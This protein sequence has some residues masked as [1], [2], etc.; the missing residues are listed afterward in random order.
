M[1]GG[2]E[3]EEV[4]CNLCGEENCPEWRVVRGLRLVRSRCGLVFVSPR[5]T[6]AAARQLYGDSYFHAREE[7]EVREARFAMYRLEAREVKRRVGCGRILDV[8]CGRGYFLNELGPEFEKVGVDVSESALEYARKQLGITVILGSLESLAADA[9]PELAPNSYD[10]VYFRGVLQH[11]HDPLENLARAHRLLKPGGLL[12][13]TVVPNI[14]SPAA[15]LFGDEFRLMLPE[16]MIYY[17]MPRTLRAALAKAGFGEVE[18]NFPYFETPYFGWM[19]AP[20]AVAGLA[21]RWW[22][23]VRGRD[24]SR[25]LSPPFYGSV[26]D[27]YARAR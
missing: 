16:V 12:V 8:G 15:R 22:A 24:S 4:P 14:A 19:D 1:A 26:M 10:A 27:A 20:R 2:A 11:L 25:Y 18:L 21:R 13:A 7:H 3:T 17:F 5:P 9:R 6:L 23:G